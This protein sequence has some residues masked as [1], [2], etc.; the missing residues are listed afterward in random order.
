M[1][2]YGP[3]NIK[4]HVI[5]DYFFVA[6]G[7]VAPWVLGFSQHQGATVYTLALAL[8]GLALNVITNNPGGLWKVLPFEWHQY[9]EWAAPPP[10]ILVPWF[11]F[12]DAGAMPW[13]L[14]AVGLAI[15]LNS[16]FTRR[17]P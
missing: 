12:S 4:Q 15:L 6:L 2:Q 9:V 17:L 16:V 7:L 5:L 3:I 13:A 14:T 11:F 8:F 10:F 1:P